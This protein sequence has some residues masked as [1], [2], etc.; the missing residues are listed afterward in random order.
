MFIWDPCHAMCTAVLIGGD[1]A[2]PPSPPAFGLV[3]RGRYLSAKLD[4]ISL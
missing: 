1:P 3:L 4:D 2:T